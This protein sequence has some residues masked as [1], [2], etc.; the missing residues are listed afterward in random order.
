MANRLLLPSWYELGSKRKF[1]KQHGSAIEKVIFYPPIR[2]IVP[3]FYIF[4][5]FYLET[6]L[7]QNLHQPLLDRANSVNISR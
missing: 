1:A 3:F 2:G 6:T 7:C 4:A 5:K